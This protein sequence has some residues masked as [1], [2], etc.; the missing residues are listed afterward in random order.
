MFASKDK[1]LAAIGSGAFAGAD[2][3][4]ARLVYR[5]GA[6]APAVNAD[7]LGQRYFDT[8]GANWYTAVATGSGTAAN[9]WKQD[10]N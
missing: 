7:F 5:S 9:D 8:S 4:A 6:G 10:S 3:L 1:A 2:D